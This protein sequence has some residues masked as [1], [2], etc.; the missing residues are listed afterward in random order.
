[1]EPSE[2]TELM[3]FPKPNKPLLHRQN[4]PEG[5]KLCQNLFEENKA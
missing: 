5:E 4:N 1:M 2:R 3:P